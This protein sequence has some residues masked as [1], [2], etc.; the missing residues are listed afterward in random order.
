MIARGPL[1]VR[2]PAHLPLGEAVRQPGA[3]L[4][5]AAPV[6]H[7]RTGRRRLL[8]KVVGGKHVTT[9]CRIFGRQ[10]PL[11][12]RLTTRTSVRILEAVLQRAQALEHRAV[13]GR[14]AGLQLLE[15]HL[16]AIGHVSVLVALAHY[17][18]QAAAEQRR[19][20]HKRRQ[21]PLA[22]L[23]APHR[24]VALQ[25]LQ[26]LVEGHARLQAP[27]E[28]VR[29]HLVEPAVVLLRAPLERLDV[30]AERDDVGVDALLNALVRLAQ[31]LE[32]FGDLLLEA[33]V[34]LAQLLQVPGNAVLL[35]AQR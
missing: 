31:L 25:C 32:V 28:P 11:Q 27:L 3:E 29:Q 1:R 18:V 30:V 7:L 2:S 16:M 13:L 20:F 10:L 17:V 8:A 12:R 19:R 33:R 6:P 23:A 21:V 34:C 35:V 14:D 15:E 22:Q 5:R 24:Q 26:L 4:R 9:A